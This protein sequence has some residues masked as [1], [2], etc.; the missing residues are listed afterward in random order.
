[1]RAVNTKLLGKND[2]TY[3]EPTAPLK[4]N[5]TVVLVPHRTPPSLQILSRHYPTWPHLCESLL[6]LFVS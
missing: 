4:T 6:N 5:L 3:S 1:M 2:F